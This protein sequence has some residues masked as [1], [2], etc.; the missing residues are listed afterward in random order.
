MYWITLLGILSVVVASRRGVFPGWAMWLSAVLAVLVALGGISVK[1]SGA[2]AAGTGPI[3]NLAFGA[4][5]VYLIEV[6]VLLLT[7]KREAPQITA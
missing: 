6:G 4:A 7:S 2:F 3:A 1:A 5:L